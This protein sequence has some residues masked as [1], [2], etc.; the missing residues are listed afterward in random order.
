MLRIPFNCTGC[1]ACISICPKNCI[2]IVVNE[3]GFSFPEINISKC[4]QCNL[5]DR[6]CPIMNEQIKSTHT[7]AYG[8]K[9]KNEKERQDS[10]SGG[11]FSL[12]AGQILDQ[13]GIV[14]GAAYNDDF[15]VHHIA[16]KDKKDMFRLQSAKYAQSVIGNSFKETEAALKSGHKVLFSGTPCQCSG[17]KQFLRKEYDNLLL[18]DLICHGVPS[19]KVWQKYIDYRSLKENKG[20]R[21]FRINMRSKISGWSRYGYSTEFDYGEGHITQIHNSQDLFMKAFGGNIC[22]RK[23]CSDCVAKGVERCTDLTL[24]DY[25]G[26]WNQYPKFD[27]DKGTSIVFVHSEKGEKILRQLDNK[28]DCIEVEIDEA[29]KEN[30]SLINSSKVHEKREEFLE[31]VNTSNFQELVLEYF[32]LKQ[33]KKVGLFKEMIQKAKMMLMETKKNSK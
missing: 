12:L 9:N 10:S 25:W 5:C 26:V 33:I 13:G 21:P 18:V 14:F 20:K 6:V 24:G 23:S 28:I 15:V 8:I 30:M 4:I 22:L 2:D 27:D 1:Q 17:L 31:R 7:Q 19:P 32:P 11:V 16:I 29:Y 3:E